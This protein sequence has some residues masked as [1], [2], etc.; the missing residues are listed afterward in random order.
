[1][2][3]KGDAELAAMDAG[4][5][6]AYYHT[7]SL[8]QRSLVNDALIR[9]S[10]G[11]REGAHADISPNGSYTPRARRNRSELCAEPRQFS[12]LLSDA[13]A[14]MLSTI[15][16]AIDAKLTPSQ[17]RIWCRY[18]RGTSLTQIAYDLGISFSWAQDTL[19]AS[20]RLMQKRDSFDQQVRRLLLVIFKPL[21]SSWGAAFRK[22]K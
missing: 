5:L 13:E 12:R 11:W 2:A 21:R 17:T 19:N 22:N 7:L 14:E 15:Q 16:D 4:E 9:L 8:S 20:Y 18:S 3:I 6:D 1:M 10:D